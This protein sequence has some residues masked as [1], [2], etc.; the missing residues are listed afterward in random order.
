[1]KAELLLDGKRT[2]FTVELTKDDKL[3]YKGHGPRDVFEWTAEEDNRSVTIGTRGPGPML[4]VRE[5]TFV[6]FVN[7]ATNYASRQEGKAYS[8][9]IEAPEPITAEP[10]GLPPQPAPRRY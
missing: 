3:E 10:S 1:M 6:A 4:P 2:G 8:Y 5:D 9:R 7:A